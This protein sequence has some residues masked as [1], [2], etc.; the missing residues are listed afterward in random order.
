[1]K[2]RIC[3]ETYKVAKCLIS[4]SLVVVMLCS[5]VACGSETNTKEP[6][7][8]ENIAVSTETA[9]EQRIPMNEY[10]RAIWYGFLPEDLKDAVPDTTTVTWMQ[11]C[12]ML[13]KMIEAYDESKLEEWNS[14]TA[15]V[16]DE[17]IVRE[18]ALLC[19]LFAAKTTDLM[20]YNCD[21]DSRYESTNLDNADWNYPI[22]GW[23][24]P[25][26]ILNDEDGDGNLHLRDALN[27]R[28]A[29]VSVVRLYESVEEIALDTADRLLELVKEDEE[30]KEIVS[31][32]E[33][34]K[35]E[36]LNSETTITKSDTYVPGETYTG[37]AYY[38]SNNGDDSA[39]GQSPETAWAT[40]EHL[41]SVKFKHG[42]IIFFERGGIWRKAQMPGSIRYTEGLT[43]SAYGEG[44]KPKIIG[45]PENGSGAEKWTLY[46]EGGDGEKI[47]KFYQEMTDCAALVLNGEKT[48]KRDLAYWNGSEY[49]CIEDF[50]VPYSMEDQIKDMELFVELPYTQSPIGENDEENTDR[51]GRA[52]DLDS[53][54]NPLTGTLYVRCDEG[55]PGELYKD[56]EFI[57]DYAA[58]DGM[59]DYTTLD[60]LSFGYSTSTIC[61][62]NYDGAANDHI[63]IQNCEAC[64]NGG[65][66][67]WFG[68]KQNS[69]GFGHAEISG[70]G[71]NVAGSYETIQNCY[72][73]HTFQEGICLESFY[74]DDSESCAGNTFRNNVIE[75]AMFGI[76]V[77]NWEE[78]ENS[79][80]I[81]KDVCIENNYSLYSGFETFYNYP[82][83]I[84]SEEYGD[85]I[86]PSMVGHVILDAAAFS[87]TE[88]GENYNI[89]GNT[90][91]FS[92]SQLIQHSELERP[93]VPNYDG[94]TYAVLL[95]FAYSTKL[96]N[97][98]GPIVADSNGT[99]AIE[100]VL[101]DKAS[102]IITFE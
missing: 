99:N 94:N 63:T 30:I 74:G 71:F 6:A 3:C 36:I 46:H 47:W 101:G 38:V 10:E 75:Y 54:G 93:S 65:S 100:T 62:G 32:A 49:V 37:T 13:G 24:A 12:N 67:D 25:I 81:L 88:G 60:N 45:S 78:D 80:H 98:W 35:Q 90:F 7:T 15:N 95:G 1:M 91:A 85:V 48:I 102:T 50:S 28:D 84:K 79:A 31:K 57:A 76:G 29:M 42:D 27:L 70:G 56:I 33:A 17:S 51:L 96:E 5:L 43:L 21:Y 19:L 58:F 20:V 92:M 69:A 64:W 4:L 97:P 82:P 14:L 83:L 8:T 39:D 52:F 16:K 18:G 34:R 11:Y 59:E 89:T 41:G 9:I 44:N 73:H 53:N 55:N 23:D 26:N 86:W 40:I 66:L 61:G 22:P 87:A 2:W 68:F 77:A 72:V